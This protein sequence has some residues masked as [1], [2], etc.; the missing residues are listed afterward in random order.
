MLREGERGRGGGGGN[1]LY[2]GVQQ[3][4]TVCGTRQHTDTH[5]YS[6]MDTV[7]GVLATLRARWT[8]SPE[9]ILL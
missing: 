3:P 6:Y 1:M 8:Y 5:I 7:H 9:A 2:E 4:E